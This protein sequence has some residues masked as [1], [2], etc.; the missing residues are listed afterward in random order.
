MH[1]IAF[2]D[3]ADKEL[4]EKLAMDTNGWYDWVKTP[5]QLERALLRVNKRLVQKNSIPIVANK[6]VIDDAVRQFTAVVFRK[7]GFGATQLDDPEGMDFGRDNKPNG[8]DW[9]REKRYDI[10]T[11]TN[12]IEGDWRLIAPA[13]PDNEI[14]ITTKL[15]MA[16]DPVSY[17]HLTLPT[18]CSV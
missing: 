6:F 16:V 2:S 4:L 18:I 5:A 10:V 17:T 13:S 14:F 3:D 1:V 8:V 9:H 15:Q 12:P 7:K 11:V